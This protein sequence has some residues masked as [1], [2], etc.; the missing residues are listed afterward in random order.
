[1]VN[2]HSFLGKLSL[3]GVHYDFSLAAQAPL[4]KRLI[5][6][7]VDGDDDADRVMGLGGRRPV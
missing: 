1:M 4:P 2:G 3:L 5:G 7:G 6:L